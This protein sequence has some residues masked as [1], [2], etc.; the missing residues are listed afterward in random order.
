PMRIGH[1]SVPKPTIGV[2]GSSSMSRY[3]LGRP[4]ADGAM[5]HPRHPHMYE[6]STCN[7]AARSKSME[8][9]SIPNP[10]ARKAYGAV[11]TYA[12][13][14]STALPKMDACSSSVY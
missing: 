7:P 11:P 2:I 9:S 6:Q 5:L 12:R 1:R 10:P 14:R 3:R 4:L 13:Y 8:L